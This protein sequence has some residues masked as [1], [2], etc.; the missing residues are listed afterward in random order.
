MNKQVVRKSQRVFVNYKTKQVIIGENSPVVVQS[1]TN[2][3]TADISST[4][5]QIKDLVQA[6]SEIVRISVNTPEAAIAVPQIR[7]QL[8]QM[9]IYVPLVGDFHYNGHTLLSAYSDCAKSLSKYRINP[10]NIGTDKTRDTQFAQ[11]IK[12]ACENNKPIRIGVN[13]G[14]LDQALLARLESNGSKYKKLYTR[15]KLITEA[16]ITSA[17]ESA[18]YAQSLGLKND[19]IV[20]SCKVS[21]VQSLITVYSELAKRCDYPLHLGL[22][23]AGMGIKGIVYSTAA[24]SIL[25]QKGIGDTIRI[26]LTPEPG[27]NRARE[28]IVAQ[29]ILQA[30]GLRKFMPTI[31]A[32]PGCGRTT[33]KTFEELTNKIQAYIQEKMPH[34]KNVYVGVENMKVA[35]MGCIVNGPGESKHANIGIS[36]PGTGEVVAAPVFIDGK[37]TV[38]LH[39]ERL[40]EKFQ[41]IILEYVQAN[42]SKHSFLGSD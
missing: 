23:E 29:E 12:V 35:V 37:K 13:W 40:A 10:G 18:E 34:W 32:C 25:L 11:I 22:T 41:S 33:S 39:G 16:L 21:D 38:T 28:V 3:N 5:L 1:M 9:E 15:N 27:S 17:I 26:S 14:S 24:L 6:G 4:V 30:I 2:T 31:I 36:L 8:D 7:E 42:Y 20:L 19:K